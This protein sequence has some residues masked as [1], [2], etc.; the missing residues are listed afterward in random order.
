MS[1]DQVPEIRTAKA[2]ER[3]C[4]L[5]EYHAPRPSRTQGHH[6]HPVYLQNRVYGRIRDPELAWLCGTCH[7]AVHDW[8]SYLLGEARKPNPVPGRKARAEAQRTYEWWLS[9]QADT[10]K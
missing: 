3:P 5:Y 1:D 2:A 9:V 6:R 8:L 4:E 10:A 7:D